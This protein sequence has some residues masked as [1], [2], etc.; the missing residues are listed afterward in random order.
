MNDISIMISKLY[1]HKI[2][3]IALSIFFVLFSCSPDSVFEVS[4]ICINVAIWYTK[5]AA[6][7]AAKGE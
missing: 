5:F 4:S 3:L 7:L 6:K 1:G 2:Y